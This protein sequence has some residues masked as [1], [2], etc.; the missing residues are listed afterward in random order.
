[1]NHDQAIV[2]LNNNNVINQQD[3]LNLSIFL[4][5]DTAEDKAAFNT[6]QKYYKYLIEK[7]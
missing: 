2:L 6:H 7:I 1:M 5:N 4:E 3:L